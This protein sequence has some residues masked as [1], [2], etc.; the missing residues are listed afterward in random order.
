KVI[1]M[2]YAGLDIH[3]SFCQA[4]LMTEAGEVIKEAEILTTKE[5][6]T[7]FF[8][9]ILGVR[10][11]IESTGIWEPV[12]DWLENLGYEVKL[13]HPLKTKAIA[14]A[15]VKTD[16]ISARILADL[17]RANLLPESYIPPKEI[18]ELRNICRERKGI[19]CE[20][21][22]WKNRIKAELARRGIKSIFDNLYTKDGRNWLRSL[23]IPKIT[24]AI[25]TV[26]FLNERIKEIDKTIKAK[27]KDIPEIKI[28]ETIP[29][30]G[31]YSATFIYAEIGE[32]DRFCHS[33][34]VS[35]Y[36]GVVP[37]TKQSSEHTKHGH[38]TK[39]GSSYLRWIL[40]ECTQTHVSRYSTKLTQFYRRIMLR[41]G[42]QKAIV[43]TVRKLTKIIYWMLKNK[44][45][46]KW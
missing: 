8:S 20:R 27:S 2:L 26:E 9:E 12:F 44:E 14:Y 37:S 13:A 10:V 1:K 30:V 6:I 17:L 28:L 25:S 45:T 18:R 31:T 5:D 15:K 19:V 40:T 3:K 36:A 34:K 24:R 42:K 39:E 32:I 7:K 4:I 43:A 33:E 11:A 35:M 22:R 29:G 23:N 21:T 38:I 46:F 16:K 41:R